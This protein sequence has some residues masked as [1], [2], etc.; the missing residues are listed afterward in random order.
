MLVKFLKNQLL[1]LIDHFQ[2]DFNAHSTILLTE[3]IHLY[4][5]IL[6]LY[7]PNIISSS[8]LVYNV[9][10]MNFKIDAHL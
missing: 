7:S 10:G 4:D 6:I 2:W 8:M 9:C 3:I 1:S 5:N